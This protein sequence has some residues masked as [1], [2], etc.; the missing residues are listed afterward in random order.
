MKSIS[1]CLLF[2]LQSCFFGFAQKHNLKFEHLD[3]TAGLSQNHIMCILQDSR[4]FMWLGTRDGLNKYDGYKFTVYKNIPNDKNSL[5][6]NYVTD[7]IEDFDGNIWVSTFGG[8]LNMF[9]W[10]KEKFIRLPLL[11]D[12]YATNYLHAVL[13]DHKGDLWI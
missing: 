11:P 3:I 1:Y 5:S 7:I 9:Y 4:G 13:Q 12:L 10:Q 2:F 6:H 8:G